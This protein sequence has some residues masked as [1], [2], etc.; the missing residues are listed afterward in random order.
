MIK[1]LHRLRKKKALK[2]YIHKLPKLLR[3]DYGASERYTTGQVRRS[4]DRYGL[5]QNYV[6]YA[7]AMFVSKNDFINELSSDRYEL[8]RQEIADNYFN[9]DA[10]FTI[11]DSGGGSSS[12]GGG[13]GSMDL[14]D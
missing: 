5:N 11:S 4:I 1:L 7:Y 13:V 3:K 6:M 10:G 12:N 2:S 9:G 8:I 14:N